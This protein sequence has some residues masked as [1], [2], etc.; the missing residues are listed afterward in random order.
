MRNN[1]ICR[2]P[3]LCDELVAGTQ[4]CFRFARSRV[5]GL[6]A[7]FMSR[8][9]L[10]ATHLL[11]RISNIGVIVYNVNAT[12]ILTGYLPEQ[13][14]VVVSTTAAFHVD[15]AVLRHYLSSA[16]VVF[17]IIAITSHRCVLIQLKPRNLCR[18]ST[19]WCRRGFLSLPAS[20]LSTSVKYFN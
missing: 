14:A 11:C 18:H 4:P 2:K 15:P 1:V 10:S 16:I 6:L 19:R 13:S 17:V 20:S 12:D 8:H 5:T 7:H 3:M 9:H